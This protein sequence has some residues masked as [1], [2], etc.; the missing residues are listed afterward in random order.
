MGAVQ[1]PWLPTLG[2]SFAGVIASPFLRHLYPEQMHCCICDESVLCSAAAWSAHIRGV[3]CW[4]DS[5]ALPADPVPRRAHAGA[6][7]ACDRRPGSC[8][9][10]ERSPEVSALLLQGKLQGHTP[11][12][13]IVCI[14]GVIPAPAVTSRLLSGAIDVPSLHIIGDR[15][16]IRQVQPCL[17]NALLAKAGD[18]ESSC[19]PELQ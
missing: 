4:S 17:S 14:G 13:F 19:R 1:Q 6:Q 11:L 16:Y 8:E 18:H 12:K 3:L 9:A 15:D 10:G 2:V 5:F 7:P